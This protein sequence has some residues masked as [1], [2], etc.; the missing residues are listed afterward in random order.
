[1]FERRNSEEQRI[2]RGKKG[3]FLLILF[4]L[5]I[6]SLLFVFKV[7]EDMIDFEVNYTAGKRLAMGESLYQREDGHFMFKYFPASAILY[8]P[9]AFLPLDVAKG[10]WYFIVIFSL[11]LI[12]CISKEIVF[13]KAATPLPAVLSFLILA[14]FFL[15]E[16]QL[17][18]INAV[19]TLVLLSVVRLMTSRDER[20]SGRDIQAGILCGLASALKPYAVIFLPYFFIKKK[21]LSLVSAIG[22]LAFALIVP[23]LFF[24]FQ[25]NITVHREWVSTLSSTTPFLF[26]SQDNIS[27]IA[28]FMKWTGSQTLSLWL[29]A[30]VIAFLAAL[31][32]I[33]V[34]KGK[35]VAQAPV[36]ESSLLLVFIP[37]VSPLG[38]DYTLLSSLLA[39]MILIK[40]FFNYSKLWRVF[41]GFNFFIIAFSLYD[42]MG[43][44]LYSAFMTASVTTINFFIVIAYLASLRFRKM[45]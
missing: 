6:F 7:K 18:Q 41:L 32:L 43:R 12:V 20:G 45:C 34:L 10:V 35:R 25:G 3:I 14:K 39:V 24:G 30:L 31:A 9:L 13:S 17:G 37:L 23:S 28:L 4:L 42:L 36:L 19:V 15:R 40:N 8:L 21:W 11:F 2:T 22:F 16:L 26:S 5:I 33:I 38:W 29:S 44:G 27:I 1:M